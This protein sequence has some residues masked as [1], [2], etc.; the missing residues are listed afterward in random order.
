M[1]NE[2]I[3]NGMSKFS[4]TIL[5]NNYSASN[6]IFKHLESNLST[7]LAGYHLISDYQYK[8]GLYHS[9]NESTFHVDI[10]NQ[11]STFTNIFNYTS[12]FGNQYHN[13]PGMKFTFSTFVDYHSTLSSYYQQVTEGNSTIAGIQESAYTRHHQYVAKKYAGILPEQMIQNKTYTNG[14]AIPYSLSEPKQ[15][16][17]PGESI[18][19][20]TMKSSSESSLVEYNPS[21]NSGSN[22][23][24]NGN[25]NLAGFNP[26]TDPYIIGQTGYSNNVDPCNPSTCSTTCAT[27]IRKIL[28]SWYGCLPVNTEINSLQYRLGVNSLTFNN[29][30]YGLSIFS[31]ISSNIDY[32]IQI[33]EEQGFNN[34]DVAMNEDYN[35]TNETTGQIK[36]MSAK[37]LTGGLGSGEIAQT[38]IQNPIMFENYLGKL[39]HLTFKIYYNDGA[40]TPVWLQIP[41]GDLAFNEW[42]ATFQ[43]EES[44]AFA[45][46][47]T[48]FGEKPTVS[49][50]SNPAAMP[51]LFLT[52]PSNPNTK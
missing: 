52:S 1:D 45:D 31:T 29:F 34:M 7:V 42:E 4:Y 49:I 22:V 2:L 41:F 33:N 48:G 26:A 37:I 10:L 23:I 44:I 9:T 27:A 47:N 28:G 25:S 13:L 15:I 38:V 6:A 5:K 3:Y 39:D 11:D 43:V 24:V 17:I 32:F 19:L 14:Q 21:F 36:L 50:P 12:V 30:E 8:G 40:L 18:S 20:Q 51:Y 35:V 46:R 16:Y